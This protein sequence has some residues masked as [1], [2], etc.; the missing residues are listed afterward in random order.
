MGL[1]FV[2]SGSPSSFVNSATAEKLVKSVSDAMYQPI[3]EVKDYIRHI[4]YNDSVI[5]V[6]E[7]L[8]LTV[9]SAGWE[10]D[11]ANF[12]VVEKA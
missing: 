8:V 4:D 12:L 6:L 7:K 9:S 1:N 3:N 2:D 11:D 5:N 10:F